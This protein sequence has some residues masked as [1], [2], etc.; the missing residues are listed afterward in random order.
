MSE[1]RIHSKYNPHREAQHFVNAISDSYK[2]IVITEPGESYLVEPLR[3]RF[4]HTVLIA[5]RYTAT[6]F[7][8]SD[9]LW[10]FVWRPSSRSLPFFLINHIPDELLAS[11]R[12][13]S[14]KPADKAFP[15]ESEQIWSEIQS[16]V[17]MI[18]Q[19]MYTRSFFGTRWLKNSIKNVIHL[20]KPAIIDFGT[21]DFLLTG[22]GPSLSDVSPHITKQLSTVTVS[23]A[24]NAL[25][26]KG[27][28]PDLCISTDAGYWALR[29]FDHIDT[30]LPIAF[31]L[32]AAIPSSTLEQNDCIP[33][34]Y[35]SP[36]EQE[37]FSQ[38]GFAVQLAKENGTVMGTALELL[39][40]HTQKNIF[41]SGLD[42]A[43]TK[44]FSHAQPHSSTLFAAQTTNKVKSL[45]GTLTV[46]NF[47][48]ESLS[49]YRQW[50]LQLPPV[51]AHRITYMGNTALAALNNETADNR[52]KK[53]RKNGKPISITPHTA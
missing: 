44:G 33:L 5:I 26:Y 49:V 51:K 36:L 9:S 19:I 24:F 50:F 10:D 46:Q 17:G 18:K 38:A 7:N 48:T 12:F 28:R 23:S 6:L 13:L 4:P 45:T 35:G 53:T 16:A 15:V 41:I 40:N 42:L 8:E 14:W 32:E 27:I 34:S 22:A 29:H 25:L 52:L 3:E 11:T 43:A 30:A 31:P 21:Q 47:N 1:L 37:L 2:I 39:L 20:Q